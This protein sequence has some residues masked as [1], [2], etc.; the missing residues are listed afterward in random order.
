MSQ[1]V[2]IKSWNGFLPISS[3]HNPNFSKDYESYYSSSDKRKPNS[4]EWNSNKIRISHDIAPLLSPY[5]KILSVGCGNGII[6]RSLLNLLP[7]NIYIHGIDPFISISS[8]F[9]S[10]S[11][12]IQRCSVYEETIPNQDIV[13]MNTVDY[14][15]DDNE[16]RNICTRLKQISK[17]G[18]LLSQL[19]V[20]E[21]RYLLSL[22]YRISTF[23][24]SLPFT[25]YSFWGWQRTFDEHI[26]LLQSCGF[27]RFTLGQH[28]TGSYWIHAI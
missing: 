12:R 23:I 14:A 27:A 11:L 26:T 22:R 2:F 8:E 19:M 20:P 24:K 3:R 6:E 13:F 17:N 25:P 28:S 16:Y 9:H 18:L 7:S 21:L 1:L 10:S 5:K 15:L 4:P